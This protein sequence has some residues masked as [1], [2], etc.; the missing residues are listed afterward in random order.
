MNVPP[1]DLE[2]IVYKKETIGYGMCDS[3]EDKYLKVFIRPS[4]HSI[5]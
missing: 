3:F 5:D 1:K 2:N 4:K